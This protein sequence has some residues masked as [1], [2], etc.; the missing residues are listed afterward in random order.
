MKVVTTA[1]QMARMDSFA[2]DH[3]HIPGLI[4]MENAGRGIAEIAISMLGDPRD[5]TAHIYCG[6]GN[7]GG[8]GYVVA[9][10]LLNNGYSIK[11]FIF[12]SRSHIKG[13]AL[14]NL[15]ILENMGQDPVWVESIS[16][17]PDE[18]PHLLIDALL[19]TGTTG[20][21]RGLFAD[22]VERLN[23]NPAPKLAIDI[24][25]GVNA[26]TGE[27]L[28]TA[29]RADI[30]ATMALPKAGLLLGK[31]RAHTGTLKIIDIGMPES[32]IAENSTGVFLVEESDILHLLPTRAPNAHKNICGTVAVIAGSR[33]FT[34]AATLTSKAVL[35]AGAGLSYLAIPQ[36][37]NSILEVKLTE[38]ITWPFDDAGAGYLHSGCLDEMIPPLQKQN[39]I[40]IGPGIGQHTKTA[41]LVHELLTILKKPIVLD[42]DGLNVCAGHV[43]LITNYAGPMILTPH[44]GEL[45]RLTDISTAEIVGDPINCARHFA[46]LWQ[47]ILILKGGPTIIALPDKRVFINSTGNAGMA[48][49][50]SGDVLTGLLAGLMAQGLQAEQAALVGVYI[51]GLAGDAARD[52][53]GEMGMI[54]GDILENIPHVLSTKIRRHHAT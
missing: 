26:D 28:G 14:I 10:H 41:A 43:D 6:P 46:A 30:T 37:L 27:V 22:A 50:G 29:V 4:L 11:T 45:A 52:I 44:P 8:D 21:P 49:A 35:R 12:S 24:P 53:Y 16:E 1:K 40:A 47:K 34:G 18:I 51:H 17:I 9:R 31:G 39:I 2:I 13:D 15:Q 3:L 36:S 33:G 42:A 32:V 54:A 19:G 48:T 20:P 23:V 25:T 5:K 7:N 38:V